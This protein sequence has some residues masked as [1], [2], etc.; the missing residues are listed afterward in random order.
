MLNRSHLRGTHEAC[1]PGRYTATIRRMGLFDR[2]K[3]KDPSP[4]PAEPGAKPDV[5]VRVEVTTRAG[6]TGLPPGYVSP[7][8]S[9]GQAESLLLPGHDR[10]PPL[11]FVR[12]DGA[13]WLAEDSTGLLVNVGNRQLRGLGI[14][15]CRVR[16]DGYAPGSLRLGVV[17]L[18][19]EPDN[20]HDRNAVSIRQQ[21]QHVGY[22][23]KGMAPSVARAIDRGDELQAG[24][25]CLSIR[26][27]WL[28][29][30][31]RSWPTWCAACRTSI[32]WL[33]L[34]R[35]PP[36]PDSRP[37]SP[38]LNPRSTTRRVGSR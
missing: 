2:F 22:F 24:G 7:Y 18:F 15:S 26:R 1:T 28:R 11:H 6:R 16:G 34:S 9:S 5:V 23:N 32:S 3:K 35:P 27:R 37:H 29:R 36:K 20:A 19:R 12:R 25:G 30:A 31:R 21:G 17:E 14:W 38:T 33:V 10:L 8:I 4:A 13:W